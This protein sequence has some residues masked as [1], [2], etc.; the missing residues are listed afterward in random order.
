MEEFTSLASW[1]QAT[2]PYG[3][4]A[5]LGSA[6]WVMSER[7]DAAIQALH[8]QVL[9]LG[10]K[11]VEAMVR[12]EAALDKATSELSSLKHALRQEPDSKP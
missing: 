1:L 7:K 3:L 12:F 4:V 6:F 8:Q 9:E 5:A 10:N 2:G 11:Q